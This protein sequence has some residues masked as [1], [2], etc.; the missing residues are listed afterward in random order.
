[1]CML[2]IF[3]DMGMPARILNIFLFPA[4]SS[5]MFWDAV[6]LGGYLLLKT[7]SSAG[8]TRRRAPR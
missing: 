2:F 7:S 1:M 5:M 3:V 4:P 8:C 6:A